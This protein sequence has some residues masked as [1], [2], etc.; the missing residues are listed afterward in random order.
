MIVKL[1]ETD[2]DKKNAYE[3][4]Y[5]VFTKEMGNNAWANHEAKT[6][7][8]PWDQGSNR[9]FV[10]IIDNSYAATLRIVFKKEVPL[11][12]E[13]FLPFNLIARDLGLEV[14]EILLNLGYCERVA[15]LSQFRRT[16]VFRSLF[17]H[18]HNYLNCSHDIKYVLGL[19]RKDN[20]R[21]IKVFKSMGYE[22]EK[23][24]IEVKGYEMTICFKTL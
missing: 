14:N 21:A 7:I 12:F 10:A 16:N 18:I 19:I 17:E 1:A 11:Q 4:R 6:F 13:Q 5:K 2:E 3:I 15:V 24:F 9:C 23:Y 8:D 22:C 20:T